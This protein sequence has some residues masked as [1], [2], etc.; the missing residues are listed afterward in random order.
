MGLVNPRG[1]LD[2][3]GRRTR[4]NV[5]YSGALERYPQFTELNRYDQRSRLEARHQLTPRLQVS[6]VASYVSTPST[7]RL[8]LEGGSLPFVDVGSKLL[9]I[10]GMFQLAVSPRTSLAGRYQFQR[11]QFDRNTSQGF[12]FLR[13][14][15][16][17]A[18]SLQLVHRLTRRFGV[19]GAWDY[20]QADVGGGEQTFEVQDLTGNVSYQV[21]ETTTLSGSAGASYLRVSNTGVTTWGPAFSGALEHRRGRTTV[22]ASYE[23][24]FLPSFS[25][26]GLTANQTMAVDV[27]VPFAN[28][29]AY[30][31]GGIGYSR[32]EPVEAL[33]VGFR[34]NSRFTSASVGYQ[35]ARW[36]RTEG[37]LNL[38]HQDSTA[39]GLVDRTRVGFQ[40]V[41]FK[42][43]RI[44]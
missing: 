18:P 11:A 43:V 19:G 37:F 15:H 28:D 32:T 34:V 29:R 6:S 2:F 8:Q 14:G 39:R 36:L 40:F 5:G 21:L 38:S 24:A 23:R 44:Q 35:V 22:T 27:R 10:S 1:E 41:T 9:D 25:F 12:E 30:V 16:S 17:H 13:G 31:S 7:D 20:R 26:G 33:G 42:P 3:N 4:F